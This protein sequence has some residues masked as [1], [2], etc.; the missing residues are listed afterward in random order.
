M[1]LAIVLTAIL[2]VPAGFVELGHRPSGDEQF[3]ANHSRQWW[4]VSA[5]DGAL[6]ITRYP[7]TRPYDPLPFESTRE[8]KRSTKYLGARRVMKVAD[9]WLAG[10]DGG[11]WGGG[12]WWYDANGRSSY[13]IPAPI[14]GYHS[15]NVQGFAHYG[16]DLL[17]FMGLDHLG[18][19]SGYVF[20]AR[21]IEGQWRLIRFATLG[22]RPLA[23]IVEANRVLVVTGTGLWEATGDA[24]ARHIA[25]IDIGIMAATSLTRTGDGAL[26]VGMRR[27]VLRLEYGTWEQTWLVPSNCVK[28]TYREFDCVCD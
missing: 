23:W 28:A 11:E 20:R 22:A 21:K 4:M 9:G 5:P 2:S 10:Y 16:E 7:T 12:L 15:E 8:K 13:R 26:Y 1:H 19:R 25:P 27:F 3:C 6:S 14:D 24:P 18:I 17:V